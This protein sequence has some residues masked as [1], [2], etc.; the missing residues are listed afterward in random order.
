[1]VKTSHS[2]RLLIL[3]VVMCLALTGLAARLVLL[4]V[5]WHDKL[6]KIADWNTQS[7]SLREPRRGDILDVN[8]NPLATSV[9][10][11]KVFA[12]P[13][14][15]GARYPEVARTLAPLLSYNEAELALRLRPAIVRTN[16][17]GLLVTNAS[18]NLK[19]KVS[20]EQWQQITQAMAQLTLAWEANAPTKAEKSFCRAFR[21][22]GIYPVD[23]QQ[24]IYPSTN[25]AAHVLG[26]VHEREQETNH[27]MVNEIVGQDGIE[28]WFNSKLTGIRGWRVTE[29]DNSRQEIVVYR[30]QEVEARPGLNVVLTL[31]LVLQHI[32]EAELA[33]VMKTESPISAS[34]IIVRPRTGE[35]LA[36]ATLPNYD[37][38]EPNKAEME[39]LRNRVIADMAE[40][41]STF[42][43]VVVSAALN[44]NVVTLNDVFD[45]EHSRWYYLGH[46]LRDDHGGYGAL[47]VENIIAKSSNI[48]A[49]KIAIYKLGEERLYNYIK[50]FGF[51][52][53]TGI[54]L[55]GEVNGRVNPFGKDKLMISR[56]PMGQSVAVTPLQMVMAMAAIANRGQ[57]M[58]PMLVNRLEDV[59]RTVVTQYRPRMVRQVVGEAAAQDLVKAL[60]LVATKDGTAVKAAM[61][62]YTVAGKTGTA[63]KVIGKV[64]VLGKYTTS[65]IGFFP[66]DEPELCISV[67]LDE[68][69][70]GHYGGQIAAPVFRAI[71]EQAA[72]YLK[73]R[74][75]RD[76]AAPESVSA[77][78]KHER[79]KTASLGET[80]H[81]E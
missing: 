43:I 79:I 42:K 15:L 32:V 23:D 81:A 34:S 70:N 27:V 71:A 69:K 48:G 11:K 53:R 25:L 54:T 31:D 76:E 33:K 36:M 24:R 14:F 49:A 39:A 59:N 80:A 75:D 58:W 10:V 3:A 21:Q 68:P 26:Y 45:C 6:K 30:E 64:Y 12:N 51:G 41:G 44:E 1:M 35:I 50:A 60:K 19:R 77:L 47:T 46:L 57:L 5:V 73:I 8:G 74:P 40:P 55:G 72:S 7:F 22:R 29:A 9:P 13:R 78:T 63:Q 67:V 28:A 65:F 61:D 66:A 18:V 17:Q 52:T 16:E 4:Q 2:R 37:P 62:H 56:V 20:I 38:N